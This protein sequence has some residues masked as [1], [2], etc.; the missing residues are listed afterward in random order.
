MTEPVY[1]SDLLT[2]DEQEQFD[3]AMAGRDPDAEQID[4]PQND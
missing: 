4:E 1:T 2:P 3:K